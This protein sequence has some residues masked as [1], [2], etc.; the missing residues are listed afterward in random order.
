LGASRRRRPGLHEK[1]AVKTLVYFES[2][3]DVGIALARETRLKKF[4]RRWKMELIEKMNPS[5]NDLYPSLF[6]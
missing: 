5:W 3:A 2:Y 4:K 6:N 1:Y